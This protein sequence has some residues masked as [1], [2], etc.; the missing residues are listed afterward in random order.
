MYFTGL[1]Y[2]SR[3][4][5]QTNRDFGKYKKRQETW[6]ALTTRVYFINFILA[7]SK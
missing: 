5:N 4:Y 3:F 2:K 6:L 1:L 7:G